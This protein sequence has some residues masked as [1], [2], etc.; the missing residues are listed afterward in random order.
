[1][2][3]KYDQIIDQ[4][5]GRYTISA[6]NLYV[7][8]CDLDEQLREY[9]DY[10]IHQ[11]WV[12]GAKESENT[13]SMINSALGFAPFSVFKNILF[14][15]IKVF[16]FFKKSHIIILAQDKHIKKV[17]RIRCLS[18]RRAIRISE[19]KHPDHHLVVAGSEKD[20]QDLLQK[21]VEIIAQQQFLEIHHE[22]RDFFENLNGCDMLQFKKNP[23]HLSD[24]KHEAWV[25]RREQERE[26]ERFLKDRAP[27]GYKNKSNF[28]NHIF[29]KK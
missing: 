8:F 29:D 10:R 26:S 21:G 5:V 17:L 24:F 16:G 9:Y 19:K 15:D 27:T 23:R 28:N 11:E 3:P 1:M 4:I 12:L 22:S 13:G 18:K 6:D 2:D 20:Y 25:N 14:E 7:K